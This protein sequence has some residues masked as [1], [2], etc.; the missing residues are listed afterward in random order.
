M[1]RFAAITM[2]T[3]LLLY[4]IADRVFEKLGYKLT[5]DECE[6]AAD[7][8][9][10]ENC[11]KCV[12]LATDIISST[13]LRSVGKSEQQNLQQRCSSHTNNDNNNDNNNYTSERYKIGKGENKMVAGDMS[14][15]VQEMQHEDSR[16]AM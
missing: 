11:K 3:G 15:I 1:F 4:Q 13:H 6:L 7:N 12:Q 5:N 16:Y 9:Q 14:V 2:M 10:I 8:V